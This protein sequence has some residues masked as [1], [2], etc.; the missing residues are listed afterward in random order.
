MEGEHVPLFISLYMPPPAPAI[1]PVIMQFTNTGELSPPF[2]APFE[3]APPP[4]A[5]LIENT[6]LIISGELVPFSIPELY[7]APPLKVAVFPK[8][9]HS[10]NI[11]EASPLSA[12]SL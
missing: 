8:K 7:I 3:I 2:D 4:A 5:L 12:P 6:E 9:S 10:Y 1:F 11:G